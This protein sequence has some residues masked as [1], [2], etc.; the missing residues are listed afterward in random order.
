MNLSA[1]LLTLVLLAAVAPPATA[2][3][4]ATIAKNLAENILGKGSVRS[5]RIADGGRSVVMVWDSATYKAANS[6]AHTRELLQ[7]EAELTSGAVFQVMR[8]VQEFRFEIL[9]AR[10]SLCSGSVGRNRPISITF[11][12][13]LHQ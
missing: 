8:A 4:N 12:P 5:T 9:L 13:R 3:D 10:Q 7:V 11:A 1:A 6:A 2:D